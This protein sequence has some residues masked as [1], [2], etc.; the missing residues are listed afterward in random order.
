[1]SVQKNKLI[2]AIATATI[3]VLVLASVSYIFLPL[4]PDSSGSI[5][6]MWVGGVGSTGVSRQPTI[7]ISNDGS[8]NSTL[9]QQKDDVYTQTGDLLN[10]TILVNKNDIVLDGSGWALNGSRI[11]LQACSNVTIRNMQL[12]N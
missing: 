6:A 7:V 4:E 3:A 12:I 5:Y 8:V 1:M 10:Q 11:T 2:L 9:L